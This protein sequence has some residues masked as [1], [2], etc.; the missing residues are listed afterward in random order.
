MQSLS[1]L[2]VSPY[3]RTH[4]SP[5][6]PLLLLSYLAPHSHPHP[7][8]RSP[9]KVNPSTEG[10]ELLRVCSKPLFHL[11]RRASDGERA[12]KVKSVSK[13]GFLG[14]CGEVGLC[15]SKGERG[16][17]SYRKLE[18]LFVKKLEEQQLRLRQVEQPKVL[19]SGCISFET[20]IFLLHA[21][22]RAAYQDKGSL[23]ATRQ[24][25][26]RMDSV[27]GT[28]T[29]QSTWI[30]LV[31]KG[32]ELGSGL[33]ETRWVKRRRGGGVGG[34]GGLG[35][36]GANDRNSSLTTSLTHYLTLFTHCLTH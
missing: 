6:P 12:G 30:A 31:R 4:H 35:R 8:P 22:A 19:P 24:L 34:G 26:Y 28:K 15:A 16:I 9:R 18:T 5:S 23:R 2:C 20:F 21:V 29:F 7:I 10:I 36:G 13:R 17:L 25:L 14:L 27:T 11:F 32:K 3:F 33:G 1:S